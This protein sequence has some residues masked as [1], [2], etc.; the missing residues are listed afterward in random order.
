MRDPAPKPKVTF[1]CEGLVTAIGGAE[2]VLCDVANQLAEGGYDVDVVTHEKVAGPPYFA[3]SDKVRYLPL[4][5]VPETYGP[6]RRNLV[7][8][9]RDLGRD[10]F[11]LLRLHRVPGAAY[12]AWFDRQGPFRRRL[13]RYLARNPRDVVIGFMPRA[14]TAVGLARAPYPLARIAS[15]HSAPARDFDEETG[16]NENVAARALGRKAL[17]RCD[18]ITVL[19][20]EF[21]AWY[22]PDLRERITIVPNAVS[23]PDRPAGVMRENLVLAVGR[24]I[25]V[26]GQDLL[27]DAWAR[28]APQFPDWRVEIHGQGPD[29]AELEAQIAE[30]GV[31]DSLA[32]MG[33]TRE[34][35][36]LYARAAV[37]A[38]PSRIEGF[39]LVVAEALAAGLPA[40]G[41]ADCPGV[42]SLIRD[43][44]N[45][46]LV[47]GSQDRTARVAA[48]SRALADLLADQGRREALGHAGPASV[49]PYAADRIMRL[50]EGVI[51]GALQA[52]SDR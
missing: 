20:P 4:R 32:L 43:G 45:G 50:W 10:V 2:R 52:R 34:V 15:T 29:R 7:E 1:V 21:R 30:R 13:E 22:P 39:S 9:L 28:I 44:E 12:L 14:I 47:P 26:K 36:A 33:V 35:Q 49:A 17:R 42:N 37:L 51:A 6:L 40:V 5:P 38:H 19:L 31:G 41:F 24:H 8:P 48:L 23:Q 25:D 18:R 11:A 27:I 16:D 46:V 3:L